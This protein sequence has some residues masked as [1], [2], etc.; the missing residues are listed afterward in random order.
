MYPYN[1]DFV[2]NAATGLEP[3]TVPLQQDRYQIGLGITNR[4][5]FDC[6]ICYYH[7]A[8][9]RDD[10]CDMPLAFL[11]RILEPLPRLAGIIIGLEGE[12]L[13]HPEFVKILDLCASHAKRIVLITNGSLVTSEISL[14]VARLPSKF[15]FLSIDAA[16]AVLYEQLRSGG[17]FFKFL[18]NAEDLARDS[19]CLLHATVFKQNLESLIQLPG[20]AAAL[21]MNTVSFQLLRVHPGSVARGIQPARLTE[22]KAWLSKVLEK[23]LTHNVAVVLDRFFGGPAMQEHLRFLKQAFP[24]LYLQEYRQGECAH[25]DNLAGIH[26]DGSLCP[27]AGDFEPVFMQNY[28][29]E[30]I[31]NHPYLQALRALH[32]AGRISEPCSICMNMQQR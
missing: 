10:S 32:R 23:A 14:E 21:G 31:F 19:P 20:L 2:Q 16:D 13:L 18:R 28:A 9:G 15:V 17:N 26:A 11:R 5:N 8:A 24:F 25:A 7:S 27:C 1:L 4:C 29:F 6:P 30:S 22:L 12:P 3:I